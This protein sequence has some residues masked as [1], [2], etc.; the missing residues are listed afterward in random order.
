[1]QK[2]SFIPFLRFIF[3][4]TI[5]GIIAFIFH[6]FIDFSLLNSTDSLNNQK[7]KISFH[8]SY[9]A[10]EQENKALNDVINELKRFNYIKM[11]ETPFNFERKVHWMNIKILK[12]TNEFDEVVLHVNNAMLSSFDVYDIDDKDNPVLLNDNSTNTPDNINQNIFPHVLLKFNNKVNKN[13]LLKINTIGSPSVPINFYEQTIFNNKITIAEIIFGCFIGIVLLMVVYNLVFYFA[14]KNSIYLIYVTYLLSVFFALSITTGFGY[15][16]YDEEIYSLISGKLSQIH[17]LIIIS[18]FLFTLHFL[19]YHKDQSKHYRYGLSTIGLL[20]FLAAISLFMEL[21]LRTKLF[22]IVFPFVF[23]YLIFLV[24]KKIKSTFSWARFYFLSWLPFIFYVSLQA[25]VDFDLLKTTLL[26]GNTFLFVILIEITFLAFALAE[27]MKKVEQTRLDNIR[28]HVETRLPRKNNLEQEIRNNIEQENSKHYKKLAVLVIKPEQIDHVTLYMDEFHKDQLLISLN[29]E[30]QKLL[31]YNSAILELTEKKE[32]LVL[33]EPYSLGI[34]VDENIN[35]QPIDDLIHAIQHVVEKAY[36]VKDFHFSLTANVG[37]AK[38]PENT[39]NPQ[40]LINQAQI[41]ANN[42]DIFNNHW[43]QFNNKQL[44]RDNYWLKMA[45]NLSNAIENNELE[46]HHQP[47]VDLKTLR[48]CGSE[49]LLRWY[50]QGEGFID[51]KVFVPVAEDMGLIKKLTQWVIKQALAQHRQII[52]KGYASHKIS[53]N[54]SCKDIMHHDFTLLVSHTLSEVG[55]P[56]EKI[57]L[58]LSEASLLMENKTCITILN[59]LIALGINISIDDFGTGYSSIAQICEIPCQELKMDPLFV[60]KIRENK[61]HQ[62]ICDTT[63]KMAKGLK[64]DVVA[65]GISSKSDED[66]LRNFGCDIGQGHYYAKPMSL[67]EY[68]LWLSNNA[69]IHSN[70]T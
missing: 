25:L 28:Y 42:I 68:F 8:Y 34:L 29:N 46:L 27:R 55:I 59:E 2:P 62:V 16:L 9:M 7:N 63:I 31:K 53:I 70:K 23:C 26:S 45:E 38:Y 36:K 65:E 60:E 67:E 13:I 21:D 49:C 50:Y 22:F 1:M 58:E 33:L 41:A 3:I 61:R 24:T 35:N 51:P 54:I 66:M 6:R 39:N 44:K 17:Y 18:L 40:E 48:V 19:G 56:A 47:Q 11:D 69:N 10:T 57:I 20:T 30:L 5:V 64:L 14:I 43:Q 52:E 32:K 12:Y 37:L 15:Y 4:A